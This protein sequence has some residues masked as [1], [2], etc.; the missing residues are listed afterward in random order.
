MV[1]EMSGIE[2]LEW[3]RSSLG[4]P[5]PVLFA[6]RMDQ[7]QDI[8][9]ALEKGADDY[10]AKP[11]RRMELLARIKALARRSTGYEEKQSIVELEPFKID[12][13]RRSVIRF[14]T[15]VP[16]TQKEFDLAWFL[17]R[18]RGR[19]LS[20]G[21]LLENVWGRSANINTRTVDTHVSRLRTKLGLSR[22][23]GWRLTSIYFHGY[24][25]EQLE[26]P[27]SQPCPQV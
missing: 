2:V 6:T 5:L 18:N 12:H 27:S 24:R 15:V 19:L 7:E 25:L 9:Q 10:M 17:F 14:D 21:Y 20:R 3:I 13:T 22:E 26:Q 16:L 23:I 4:W 11:V 8:V 1:P